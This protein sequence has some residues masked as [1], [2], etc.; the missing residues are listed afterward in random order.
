MKRKITS[1]NNIKK[2]V[3][4]SLLACFAHTGLLAQT[5]DTIGFGTSATNVYGPARISMTAPSSFPTKT[6]SLYAQSELAAKGIFPGAIINTISWQK[7]TTGILT[8]GSS[9]TLN[10]S[11]RDQVN[12]LSYGTGTSSSI[13]INNYIASGFTPAG[14]RIFSAT[15]NNF[16][17]DTSWVTV[18]FQTPF[19]YTGGAL[20]VLMHN[21]IVAGTGNT[22]SANV[23]WR[24]NAALL[25]ANIANCIYTNSLAAYNNTASC[26]IGSSR[27]NAVFNYTPG[28]ACS[29]TPSAGTISFDTIRACPSMLSGILRL[30]NASAAT[31]VTLQWEKKEQGQLVFAPI[32]GATNYILL[33]QTVTVPTDYHVIVTCSG[34]SVTSPAITLTPTPLITPNYLQDFNTTT[35]WIGAS[36]PAC[37]E[38]RKGLMDEPVEFLSNAQGFAAGSWSNDGWNNVGTLGAAKLQLSSSYYDWLLSPPIALGTGAWQLDFDLGIFKFNAASQ[39]V[40]GVD[41]IV[42]VVISTDG[43][44]TFSQT[45]ILRKWD[46]VDVFPVTATGGLHVTIP[47]TGY[48][49]NVVF[50]FYATGGSTNPISPLQAPKVMI[51][52]FQILPSGTVLGVKMGLLTAVINKQGNSILSW[53]TYTEENNAGFVIEKSTD[54]KT[55][56]YSGNVGSKAKDGNSVTT[57]DYS[58]TDAEYNNGK[59]FYRLKQTD[60]D[61]KTSYSNI[62]SLESGQ[63]KN[64]VFQVYPNPASNEINI[65]FQ[66][67]TGDA[68]RLTIT[69]VTGNIII[70]EKISNTKMRIDVSRLHSGI[71]FINY[72]NQSGVIVHK[73]IKS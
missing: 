41:D 62:V 60:R 9:D 15:V 4:F 31:G 1:L 35:T 23:T 8:N 27:P 39:A 29:G 3:L 25:G 42:A 66:E 44:A 11:L 68:D 55:F 12:T 70:T 48:S 72:T 5:N 37:W 6:I 24:I 61:G 30:N 56:N 57:I 33:N 46:N 40:M 28:P 2:A 38:N 64:N 32:T 54:G 59:V 67:T 65:T 10:I 20:E 21:I 19:T 36:A 51:D 43:G 26:N 52:N 13:L 69:D 18:T 71:Y 47:L 16:P 50:G 7:S 22:A 63:P 58:F 49:G 53:K 45:N 17:A 14:S 34:S 73:I